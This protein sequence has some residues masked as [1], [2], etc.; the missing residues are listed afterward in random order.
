[1]MYRIYMLSSAF[2]RRGFQFTSF[3][4]LSGLQ[5]FYVC[6]C[7]DEFNLYCYVFARIRHDAQVLRL[8]T[9]CTASAIMI[10]Y[11]LHLVHMH[12]CRCR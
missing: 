3:F 4:F 7:I 9:K 5:S 11:V 10:Y 1:M 2:E 8:R 12:A 6:L